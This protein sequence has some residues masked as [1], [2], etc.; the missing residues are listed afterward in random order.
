[1]SVHLNSNALFANY[2]P[3]TP[4]FYENAPKKPIFDN[5]SR[6]SYQGNPCSLHQVSNGCTTFINDSNNFVCM[7]NETS[8]MCTIPF[9]AEK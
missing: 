8:K 4:G 1:M 9:T 6:I 3:Y 2:N 7:E 5:N